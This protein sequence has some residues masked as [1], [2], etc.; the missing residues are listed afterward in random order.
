[1]PLWCELSGLAASRRCEPS[2]DW[3]LLVSFFFLDIFPFVLRHFLRND[4]EFLAGVFQLWCWDG[5]INWLKTDFFVLVPTQE[6]WHTFG[7]IFG[8]L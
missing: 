5:Q 3:L 4:F 8:N 2:F 6:S 1:M 7:N